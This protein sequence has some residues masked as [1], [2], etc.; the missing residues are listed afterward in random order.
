MP[1]SRTDVH[2]VVC[3]DQPDPRERGA[4]K[5]LLGALRQKSADMQVHLT[6][7]D[8][9]NL[10]TDSN[11]ILLWICCWEYHTA[12]NYAAVQKLL[13]QH[14]SPTNGHKIV[15]LNPLP[16]IQ[17]NMNKHT[18][19]TELES[20][21]FQVI[22]TIYL[23]SE[24]Y[25]D[26]QLPSLKSLFQHTS[27][28]YC[29]VKPSIS[30]AATDTLK[31]KIVD[32]ASEEQYKQL[33]AKYEGQSSLMVQ[34]F[35]SEIVSYGELSIIYCKGKFTHAVIKKPTGGDFRVQARHGGVTTKFDPPAEAI[36]YC[37]RLSAWLAQKFGAPPMYAR[38]DG[39]MISGADGKRSFILVECEILDPYLFME[40]ADEAAVN[41]YVDAIMEAARQ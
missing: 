27:L 3:A 7:Y 18:Y 37:D 15:S 5:V 1:S 13:Q 34:P 36:E 39:T 17:W 22:N 19:L 32:S 12:E 16:Q 31:L 38:L 20:A 30:A 6:Q 21:G 23:K 2:L 14:Q 29:V 25:K 26:T 8:D 40:F 11:A 10:W 41:Q 35:V 4:V 33:A 9:A 24:D 28:E